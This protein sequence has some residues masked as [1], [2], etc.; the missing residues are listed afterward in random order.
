MRSTIKI[1]STSGNHIHSYPAV[2]LFFFYSGARRNSIV[3]LLSVL[4]DASLLN[5]A[6]QQRYSKVLPPQSCLVTESNRVHDVKVGQTESSY[7][8]FTRVTILVLFHQFKN[9]SFNSNEIILII[10]KKIILVT[11]CVID[12]TLSC[13]NKYH[14]IYVYVQKKIF[15]QTTY[16]NN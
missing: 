1:F 10:K 6:C 14:N 12:N 5:V 4:C 8:Q 13:Q 7:R 2:M 15:F 9:F 16:S 3:R 11:F